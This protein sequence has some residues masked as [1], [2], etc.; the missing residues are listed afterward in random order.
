MELTVQF[1]VNFIFSVVNHNASIIITI[2]LTVH[3]I[4]F[5]NLENII[6]FPQNKDGLILPILEILSRI[7]MI[8]TKILM[9][10]SRTCSDW[11]SPGTPV[12]FNLITVV[13]YIFTFFCIE[14][15][16]FNIFQNFFVTVCE[17]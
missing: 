6:P 1:N 7:A 17:N 10:I 8:S 12:G 13:N 15:P 2:N 9:H 14:K 11:V 5:F 4:I 16:L 3:H